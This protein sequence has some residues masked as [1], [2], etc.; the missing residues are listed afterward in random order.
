[1]TTRQHPWKSAFRQAGGIIAASFVAALAFNSVPPTKVPWIR[2]LPKFDTVSVDELLGSTPA[3]TDTAA[4]AAPQVTAPVD[5]AVATPAAQ[6][7]A[8]DTAAAHATRTDSLP[9]R[10]RS[11]ADARPPA[12]S[13]APKV[14]KGIGTEAALTIFRQKKALFIDA[15]PADQFAKGHI[16]GAINVYAEEFEPHIPDLL[17]YP[18]DTL[19]VAYCGGGL[20]ELSHDL[21]NQLTTLG[22]KR[23]VVYTGGTTE[24]TAQKLPFTGEE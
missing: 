14:P 18:M 4:T 22:F 23:V 15:R 7:P 11:A 20:C 10:T 1:M 21:A 13:T 6:T 5:T 8:V 17:R 3:R 19:I 9:A 16:P 2:E 24:W 12:E